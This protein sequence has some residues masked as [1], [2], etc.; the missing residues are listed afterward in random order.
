MKYLLLVICAFILIGSCPNSE[1][2][3]GEY[4]ITCM[5]SSYGSGAETS[6]IVAYKWIT[7]SAVQVKFKNGSQKIICG[8]F[9]IE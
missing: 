8:S 4:W 9:I 3:D 5:S 2:K 6:R 1:W 7:E